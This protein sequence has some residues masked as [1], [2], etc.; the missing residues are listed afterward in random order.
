MSASRGR[1]KLE[2]TKAKMLGVR[3]LDEEKALITKAAK[4]AGKSPSVWAREILL[5]KAQE[6]L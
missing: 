6:T 5:A 2:S 4:R 3:F 1:P